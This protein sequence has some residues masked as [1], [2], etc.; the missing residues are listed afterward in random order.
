MLT[1]VFGISE[2]WYKCCTYR[3][4][5]E[6]AKDAPRPHPKRKGKGKGK[7][8]GK[9]PRTPRTPRTDRSATGSHEESLAPS[10]GPKAVGGKPQQS[11]HAE[12]LTP[13]KSKETNEDIFL[14]SMEMEETAKGNSGPKQ[15]DTRSS[16]MPELVC[17]DDRLNDAGN[18]SVSDISEDPDYD[19]EV[20]ECKQK[21]EGMG[22]AMHYIRAQRQMTT[23]KLAID[24]PAIKEAAAKGEGAPMQDT[25]QGVTSDVPETSHMNAESQQLNTESQ[26]RGSLGSLDSQAAGSKPAM[27]K[28]MTREEGALGS[29]VKMDD[30]ESQVHIRAKEVRQ[31][32]EQE[33]FNAAP[34]YPTVKKRGRR[35]HVEAP[36]NPKVDEFHEIFHEK[37]AAM[38]ALGVPNPKMELKENVDATL[39]VKEA[40]AKYYKQQEE[41]ADVLAMGMADR[42]KKGQHARVLLEG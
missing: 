21:M 19:K 40:V 1:S 28:A 12:G 32:M 36:K 14:E 27:K 24:D 13:R 11:V 20:A 37:V 25:Y 35:K 7:G 39:A 17:F 22:N 23:R 8:K 38:A 42:A 6:E 41:N 10:Q 34:I 5:M 18:S 29:L 16:K 33:N 31:I 3:D 30:Y 26:G 15:P 4:K 2:N 9:S